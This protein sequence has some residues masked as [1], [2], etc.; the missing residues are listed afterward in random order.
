MG[1]RDPQG[2]EWSEGLTPRKNMHLI[3][4]YAIKWFMTYQVA[5]RSAIPPN[6]FGLFYWTQ[7]IIKQVFHGI[8]WIGLLHMLFPIF[9]KVSSDYFANLLLI[10][11][12]AI[13]LCR[14]G[15]LVWCH[16]KFHFQGVGKK[17]SIILYKTIVSGIMRFSIR[18][19]H[20]ALH[21]CVLLDW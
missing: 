16:R 20:M 13:S 15:V 11:N 12:A 6:Y 7:R 4:I 9:G 2:E 17:S 10:S 19:R 8:L 14:A 18:S 5:H 1:V 3:P 21:K